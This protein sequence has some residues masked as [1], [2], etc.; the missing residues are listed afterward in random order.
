LRRVIR[1]MRAAVHPDRARLFV[2]TDVVLDRN[3]FLT[4]RIALFPDAQLQRT[5]IDVRRD[6]YLTLMFLE[7]QARRVPAER[8]LPGGVVD[9][10][11]GI[12]REVGARNALR[13]V[14]VIAGRPAAGQIDLRTSGRRK[15]D[16]ARKDDHA[17]AADGEGRS[18][19]SSPPFQSTGRIKERI[20]SM[21]RS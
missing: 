2:G 1:R 21:L 18:A 11:A 9:G 5:A 20:L 12:V 14:L 13:E 17:A 16:D 3:E 10:K 8:P 19:H 7:G 15:K 4:L 6:V